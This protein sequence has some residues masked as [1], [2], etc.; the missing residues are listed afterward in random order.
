MR[1]I[2][3][4]K[5]ITISEPCIKKIIYHCEIMYMLCHFELFN[6]VGTLTPGG[7]VS[8]D[9]GSTLT[10]NCNAPGVSLGWNI[11]GLS[12]INI[13]GPFLARNVAMR[14]SRITSTD[15]GGNSQVGVSEITISGLGISDNGGIIQCVNMNNN[16]TMG[17]AT[18]SVGEW[19][20]CVAI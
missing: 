7:M 11:A 2:H 12:G 18:I 9:C 17:M 3:I 20:Y 1:G 14:N 19:A 6:L 16:I 13:M 5:C 8:V 15:T 4:D 10:F